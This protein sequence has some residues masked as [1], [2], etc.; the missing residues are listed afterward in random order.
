M[1]DQPVVILTAL[2]L[3]YEA[4]R[5]HLDRLRPHR[6]A[7][8]TRFETGFLPGTRLPV[9][10]GLTGK[11]NHT[12]AVL[13]E[14]A[15][16]E[17][18][19]AALMF[20]GVAGALWDTPPLGDVVMATHV[21]AYHGGTSEDDGL[22]ARPRSWETA[23]EI[24]QLG[25]YLGRTADWTATAHPDH[26][27]PK[28]HFGPIAAGEIVQNSR[29]SHEARW[30]R[31]TYNDALAIEM[32]SAGVAQA[33]HLSGSPVA[34]VRGISDR[35]DGTKNTGDDR[36]WQ[37]VAAA[38]AA[39]FALRLAEELLNDREN[40]MPETP[41]P[42]SGSVVNTAHNSQ[43]GIQAGSITGSTVSV[44]I[45]SPQPTGGTLA[46]DLAALRGD[47]LRERS[48]GRLDEPTY[49]AAQAELDLAGKALEEGTPQSRSM[50]SLALRQLRG[51]LEGF[52]ELAAK[53]AALIAAIQG[54][55]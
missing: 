42:S 11:G 47:L 40:P 10:L 36:A 23:H 4:V 31:Q 55:S 46:A 22:K 32:E 25:T 43:I 19:P 39:A 41:Q 2:N 34:V 45:S 28:A 27:S 29:I 1:T 51:R 37:P 52:T 5:R 12:A 8:G 44:G 17:F 16:Q 33:G 35:A 7:R 54:L 13:A 15:V 14:R 49:Q 24:I 26:P 6:H 18:S 53:V 38:N 3:E 21:Y 9:A 48:S 20:V 50:S 30:I